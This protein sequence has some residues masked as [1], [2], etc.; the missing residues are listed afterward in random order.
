MIETLITFIEE[1]LIPLGGVGLFLASIIEEVVVPIPAAVVQLGAGYFLL[2]NEVTTDFAVTMI[3]SII[4]PIALG[5]SIG[6]LAIYYLGYFTG[7]PLLERWGKYAGLSWRG[8]ER[9]HDKFKSTQA[10]ATV[11]FFL[12]IAPLVPSAVISLS[13][14]VIRMKLWKY[15]LYTFLGTMIRVAFLAMIGSQVGVFY[16]QYWTIIDRFEYVILM[17]VLVSFFIF[18][19]YKLV[20]FRYQESPR[21]SIS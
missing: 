6:S 4:V 11:L 13:C 2:P 8:V 16:R 9:R 12:R 17:A 15:L 21:R 20:W 10:D 5:V 14:G 1:T 18:M 3:F 19:L 7:K